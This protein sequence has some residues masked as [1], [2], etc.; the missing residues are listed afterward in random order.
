MTQNR[1]T[2]D[3]QRPLGNQRLSQ[4]GW[5]ILGAF[6]V[7]FIVA[8]IVGRIFIAILPP[9]DPNSGRIWLPM[10]LGTRITFGVGFTFA[11]PHGNIPVGIDL[12]WWNLPGSLLGG[13]VASLIIYYYFPQRKR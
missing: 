9:L 5:I 11:T 3:A 2:Q 13:I 12:R 7:W 10:G 8:V 6:M 4:A 1:E